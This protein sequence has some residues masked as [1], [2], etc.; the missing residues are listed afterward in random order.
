MKVHQQHYLLIFTSLLL[1]SNIINTDS[2]ATEVYDA[3][4]KNRVVPALGAFSIHDK[5]Q[6]G[7]L[8]RDEYD[9]FLTKIEDRRKETGRPMHRFSSLLRFEDIDTNNDEGLTEDEILAALNNRL[10]KNRRYRFSNEKEG[11]L[12]RHR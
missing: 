6:N 9:D 1:L 12:P 5:D 8:S 3:G 10:R 7:S 11:S 4:P 2:T